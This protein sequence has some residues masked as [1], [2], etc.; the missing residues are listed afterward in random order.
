[1][2]EPWGL[3]PNQKKV[4]EIFKGTK[5]SQDFYLTGG[6]A[7]SAFYLRHRISKDLDFFTSQDNLVLPFSRDFINRFNQV[8]LKSKI[9][10]EFESF[11]EVLTT[12]TDFEDRINLVIIHIAKDSPFRVEEPK[13]LCAGL[14][15]DS[16][17]DIAT[18]KILTIFARADLRDFVDVYFLTV[19]DKFFD[20]DELVE[21]AREKDPGCDYYWLAVSLKE[22]E[23]FEPETMDILMIKRELDFKAMKEFFIEKAYS[24]FKK[25]KD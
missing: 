12:D 21:K 3:N 4:L 23:K 11:V 1:M 7:L 19:M 14:K 25:V 2:S 6:T 10:R 8:A 24:V 15:V 13:E 5:G 9:N 22:I 20:F 18:N 17:L 16:L